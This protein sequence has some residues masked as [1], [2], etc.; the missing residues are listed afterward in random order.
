MTVGPDKGLDPRWRRLQM[1]RPRLL[2]S[3]V[4]GAA[5]AWIATDGQ[6]TSVRLI[7]GW[8]AAVLIYL[9][10]LAAMMGGATPREMR[11]RAEALDTGRWVMLGLTSLAAAA[12]LGVIATHLS[13]LHDMPTERRLLNVVLAG[14]TIVAS[15]LFLHTMFAIHYAH[16]YYYHPRHDDLGRPPGGLCFPTDTHPDYW[17]FLYFSFVV[18]M[19]CQVSD[20]VVQSKPMRHQVLAHG[21]LAF[22]FN[23]VVLALM[24]NITASLL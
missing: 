19:T 23:T 22:F 14:G 9:V 6:Q 13:N 16:S 7:V 10:L 2:L 8:D 12:S 5:I 18:G 11:E 17:D 21:V 4:A 15:W 3:L 20:V 1:V 24:V